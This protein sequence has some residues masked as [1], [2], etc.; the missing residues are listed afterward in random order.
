[1]VQEE[2]PVYSLS[3]YHSGEKMDQLSQALQAAD[4]DP[5]QLEQMTPEMKEAVQYFRDTQEP[6]VALRSG[7]Q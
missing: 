3:D 5:S 6:T 1:M 2:V 4:A 7:T